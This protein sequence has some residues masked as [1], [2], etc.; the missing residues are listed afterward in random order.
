M[1][2]DAFAAPDEPTW[3]V[4]R[5][6]GGGTAGDPATWS[7]GPLA[8][9][10]ARTLAWTVT[11]TRPGSYAVGYRLSGGRGTSLAGGRGSTGSFRVMIGS[12]PA[13]TRVDPRTGGVVVRPPTG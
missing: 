11:A 3:I 6:P 10:A 8:P 4:D 5:G 9:G 13:D 2:I 12:S 7:I 1:T